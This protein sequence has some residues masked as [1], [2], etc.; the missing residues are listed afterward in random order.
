MD[1]R[2]R[3]LPADYKKKVADVDREYYGTVAGQVGPLQARLEELAGGGGLKDLLGLCV[4]AFGDISTD[5]DRLI[6]ALAES[7]ALYLSREAGRPLS[8]RES[9]HIL[10]QYR[11]VLSVSFVRSQAACL[12]ARVGHLGQAA[13]ECA[14]RRTVA[15]AEGVRMRQEAAAYHAAHIRG[16]GRWGSARGPGH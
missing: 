10:G 12:V 1:R 6:R 15:M 14:G 9:G 11:R 16:R 4:G 7:R 5:L 2:A 13:R 8:D 3:L